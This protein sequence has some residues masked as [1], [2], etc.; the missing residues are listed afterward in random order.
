MFHEG[1]K[2]GFK[3]IIYPSVVYVVICIHVQERQKQPGRIRHWTW[4]CHLK[5]RYSEY[6]SLLFSSYFRYF[7]KFCNARYFSPFVAPEI[8]RHISFPWF[9]KLTLRPTHLS[10]LV[11]HSYTV[12]IPEGRGLHIEEK[13]QIFLLVLC[14]LGFHAREEQHV[15]HD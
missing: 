2:K 15:P 5:W 13:N 14:A 1:K 11:P 12:G 7:P 4:P 3:H 6:V 9:K 8:R 10:F